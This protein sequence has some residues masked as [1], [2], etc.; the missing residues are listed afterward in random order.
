MVEPGLALEADGSS[1]PLQLHCDRHPAAI[2]SRRQK[3]CRSW[4]QGLHAQ[5]TTSAGIAK[6]FAHPGFIEAHGAGNQPIQTQLKIWGEGPKGTTDPALGRQH[7]PQ[8]STHDGRETS[9]GKALERPFQ[10]K[11]AGD[12]APTRQQG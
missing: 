10:I 4:G 6:P 2:Q 12:Q 1:T 3:P 7:P 8:G 5:A 9:Q 11:I